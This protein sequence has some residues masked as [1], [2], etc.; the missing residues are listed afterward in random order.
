MVFRE[1][2]NSVKHKTLSIITT[3]EIAVTTKNEPTLMNFTQGVKPV[4]VKLF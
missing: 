3:T 2:K 4:V 1:A